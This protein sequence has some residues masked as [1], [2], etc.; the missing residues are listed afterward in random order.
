MNKKLILAT[1]ASIVTMTSLALAQGKGQGLN[2]SLN[3]PGATRALSGKSN[4]ALGRSNGL[5][6]GGL[7]L[8]KGLAGTPKLG[9]KP[10][11]ELDPNAMPVEGEQGLANQQRILD[12]RMQQAEHLRGISE[13]NGN[14]RLLETADRMENSAVR[15]FERQTG[16][17]LPPPPTEG[18]VTD[19]NA[20]QPAAPTPA[21]AISSQPTKPKAGF[22]L[23]S[24]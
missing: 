18:T 20:A 13:R 15:N 21:P 2:R 3:N 8:G 24:R 9:A 17:V 19:P 16:T 4:G 10:I 7:G 6:R 5:S 22:W 1:V 14:T 11:P 12:Q 23:R